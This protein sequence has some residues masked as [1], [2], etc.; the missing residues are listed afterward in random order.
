MVIFCT[1]KYWSENIASI[2]I[3][4]VTMNMLAGSFNPQ[5]ASIEITCS[6]LQTHF[7]STK[8][9]LIIVCSVI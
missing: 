2:A 1:V 6:I 8:N 5:H 4:P 3:L 9:N 7:F